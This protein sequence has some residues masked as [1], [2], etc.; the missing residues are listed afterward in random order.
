MREEKARCFSLF[1]SVPR[2][3]GKA[4]YWQSEVNSLNEIINLKNKIIKSQSKIIKVNREL[5][6]EAQKHIKLL[7]ELLRSSNIAFR[8]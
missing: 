6:R 3:S 8:E 5:I 1:T 2:A 7:E 4:G